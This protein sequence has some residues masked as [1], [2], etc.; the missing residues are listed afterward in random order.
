MTHICIYGSGSSSATSSSITG[1][2]RWNMECPLTR[3]LTVV[4]NYHEEL[5]MTSAAEFD[6]ISAKYV[7]LT[8]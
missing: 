5:T 1:Q 4:E 2:K 3:S 7:D 8:H 6:C